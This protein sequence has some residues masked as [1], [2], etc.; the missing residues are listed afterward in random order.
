MNKVFLFCSVLQKQI[1]YLWQHMSF[2]ARYSKVY[3]SALQIKG[4][5]SCHNFCNICLS[6]PINFCLYGLNMSHYSAPKENHGA[7]LIHPA[8][9]SY[10]YSASQ[11]RR[12]RS[13]TAVGLTIP[14]KN[15]ITNSIHAV[16][17]Y[18]IIIKFWSTSTARPAQ[19]SS[20]QSHT[21]T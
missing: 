3:L 8:R 14:F 2:Q 21:F 13:W 19:L 20:T 15:N 6:H 7:L 9:N 10:I 17:I 12:F 1:S 18:I 4:P 11:L 16:Y 5:G